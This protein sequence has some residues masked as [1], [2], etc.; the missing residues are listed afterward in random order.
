MVLIGHSVDWLVA[1]L[2]VVE[3]VVVVTFDCRDFRAVLY[4]VMV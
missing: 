2:V 4:W 3:V 1:V